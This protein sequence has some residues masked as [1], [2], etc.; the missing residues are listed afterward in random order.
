MRFIRNFVDKNRKLY[1]AEGSR[2]HKL[3]PLFDSVETFLFAPGTKTPARG[4]H[5]RDYI[6]LKRTMTIVIYALIPCLL[7]SFYNTGYQHFLALAGM[8]VDGAP[9]PY[10][11][12]WL[13]S[14]VFPADYAPAV[15]APGFWD[16]LV[17]GLQQMVP[18]IVVSY[19]VGLGIE[20]LFAIIRKEE[21]SEGYLV[22]GMLI[23]LIVPASLPL[24]QLV[25]A[26]AFAVILAKEVFGGTGMNIFNPA[27]MV[28]AFLFFAYAGQIS[29]SKVWV[30]GN[31]TG[32][33]VDGY[34]GATPLA[35]AAGAR[36]TEAHVDP[37]GTVQSAQLAIVDVQGN[38]LSW[39]DLFWGWCPGSAGETSA[40]ACLL[41]AA[42]LLFTGIA[43]WRIM[44]AGVIG[45]CATAWLLNLSFLGHIDGIG[46]LPPHY[47]LV[48]GGFAFGLVFMATDPV[49]GPETDIGK[50]IY[51]LLIGG[52]TV[53]VRAVNPAYPEGTMLAILLLNAFAPTIDHFVLA[54]NIRRRKARNG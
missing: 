37:A 7:F 48:M 45:L 18:L 1:H 30:A 10:T 23:A 49:S 33:L 4:P 36:L 31:G 40:F 13:Q 35:A 22:S 3:W 5:V 53:V 34:S 28:R 47:H 50:W 27:M 38:A 39:W 43:S 32:S 11:V 16:I 20:V 14:L 2:F 29:G 6:D 52:L 44:A 46:S 8:A 25:I 54:A 17:F 51:G 15:A 24:W 42:L 12:G 21:V 9:A 19:A 26:I 41:G